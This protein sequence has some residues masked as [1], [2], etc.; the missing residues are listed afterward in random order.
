MSK[1]QRGVLRDHRLGTS[2][3]RR[4]RGGRMPGVAL[5]Q[6]HPRVRLGDGGR[7]PDAAVSRAS[8][9]R[10][11]TAL[12]RT[13]VCPKVDETVEYEG[14]VLPLSANRWAGNAIDPHGYR[15]IERFTLEG[16]TPVWTYAV[17][18]GPSP[19]PLR[20]RLDRRDLRWRCAVSASRVRRAGVV[21]S[22]DLACL[23]AASSGMSVSPDPELSQT[24][25]KDRRRMG[26]REPAGRHGQAA[27]ICQGR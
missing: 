11:E 16:T 7:H 5:H 4:P 6:R 1:K 24:K 2:G 8:R 18:H 17:A 25:R 12:G 14:L 20:A 13:L 21:R 27:V 10:A 23:A 19:R 15:T 9:R 26:G 22:R 3:L